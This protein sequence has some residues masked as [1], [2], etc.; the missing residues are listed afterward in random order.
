MPFTDLNNWA[1]LSENL[2][3]TGIDDWLGNQG[4]LMLHISMYRIINS[5]LESFMI[6]L[7]WNL[8]KIAI[9]WL[10]LAFRIGLII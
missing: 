10:N 3:N 5:I 1:I 4:G 6:Y 8:I 7:E 2:P 9:K